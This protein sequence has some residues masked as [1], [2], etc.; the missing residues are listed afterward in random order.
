[1][2]ESKFSEIVPDGVWWNILIQ[3][4]KVTGII[5]RFDSHYAIP[6]FVIRLLHPIRFVATHEIHIHTRF[7]SGTKFVE[8]SADPGNICP[9]SRRL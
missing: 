7:H 2:L 6:S 5:M 9:I 1:M 3:P 4:K 8:D